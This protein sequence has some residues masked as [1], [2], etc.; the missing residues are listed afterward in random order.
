[1]SIREIPEAR[2][3]L[4]VAIHLQNQVGEEALLLVGLR[5]CNLAQVDPVRL[6]VSVCGAEEL[7]VRADRGKAVAFLVRPGRIALPRVND[8]CGEIVGECGRLTT[9]R[10]DAAQGYRGIRS[11]SG[12]VGVQ[13]GKARRSVQGVALSGAVKLHRLIRDAAA[14][15]CRPIHQHVAVRQCSARRRYPQQSGEPRMR[16]HRNQVPA[17]VHPVGQHRDLAARQRH[18][19]K[20]EDVVC[21]QGRWCDRGNI[22]GDREG[23]ESFVP[24][25]L[26]VVPSERG[27]RAGDNKDRATGSLVRIRCNGVPGDPDSRGNHA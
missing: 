11:G 7:V 21:G 10:S 24:Q 14:D 18:P 12:C 3:R 22:S 17:A 26:R 8:R 23:V 9:V 15:R 16:L 5:N 13:R 27:G 25:D 1:M 20:D 4:P 19:P 6:R 2:Q